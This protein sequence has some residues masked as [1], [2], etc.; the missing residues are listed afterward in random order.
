MTASLIGFSRNETFSNIRKLAIATATVLL[1]AGISLS[2][3]NAYA[4]GKLNIKE[5]DQFPIIKVSQFAGKDKVDM[6]KKLKG[7]VV[8][9]DFWASWCEPCKIELPAL[10]KL[11]KKYKGKL[12]VIGV[13][14]D[15]NMNDAKSFLK[16]HPVGFD[17]VHD[18]GQKVSQELG[19]QKM[20]TSFILSEGKVVKVHEAFREGDDKKIDAEIKKILTGG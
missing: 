16:D 4:D 2:S 5:G 3:S 11:H 12:V 17:L 19:I 8:I 7:K 9:V 10:A 14:V 13:N 20:P 18:K 6:A 15:D 1:G